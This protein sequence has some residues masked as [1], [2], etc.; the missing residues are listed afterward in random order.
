MMNRLISILLILVVA[1]SMATTAFAADTDDAQEAAAQVN[2]IETEEAEEI[3][4]ISSS[5]LF[6]DGGMGHVSSTSFE[7]KA[8]RG[9]GSIE[10]TVLKALEN[11]SSPIDVSEYKVSKAQ[12]SDLYFRLLDQ[13]PELF[14]VA[15]S[16]TYTFKADGTV[17]KVFP[18]FTMSI[19][20]IPQAKAVFNTGID[21]IM[22][23][24]DSSWNRTQTAAYLHDYV[25][26]HFAYDTR[27]NTGE[28]VN[29]DAYSMLTEGVGVCQAYTMLYSVLLRRAGIPVTTASSREMNH[30]WNL[31]QLENGNWYHVDTTW[32]DPMPNDDG[33]IGHTYFLKSDSGFTSLLHRNWTADYTCTDTSMDKGFWVKSASAYTAAAGIEN[34]K[35][36]ASTLYGVTQNYDNTSTLYMWDHTGKVVELEKLTN[37]YHTSLD[38]Y[39][40]YLVYND[41]TN[42]YIRNLCGST[43]EAVY[44]IPAAN[45][46]N[47][48]R[49]FVLR[50]AELTVRYYDAATRTVAS[51]TV[52][53]PQVAPIDLSTGQNT[54]ESIFTDV[55]V[56]DDCYEAVMWAVEN[57]ITSGTSAT[58]FSPEKITTRGQIV[59]F[60]WRAAGC[61]DKGVAGTFTD[62]K[63]GSY[64]EKAIAWAVAEGITNGTTATT[65][66]PNNTCSKA[67]C[68]TFLWRF[69]GQ[70]GS[71][72]TVSFTDVKAGAWYYNAVQWAV[73]NNIASGETATTF[74]PSTG[75]TRANFVTYLYRYMAN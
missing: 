12:F 19:D 11:C 7:G 38:S 44:S 50:G 20:Q 42:V 52:A 43:T 26:S 47:K 58:T 67:H 37:C 1:L 71:K 49:G 51:E 35:A 5:D 14:Y 27:V 55:S 15:G 48:V 2:V 69:A 25:V 6:R 39:N 59:T 10:N 32:D 64:C 46:S 4:T 66:S 34:G 24:V 3:E 22:A 75:L 72:G 29:H 40:G 62:V 45:K 36:F 33:T 23:S 30:M 18:A 65:F 28:A 16:I 73:T 9:A 68:L 8:V 54:A 21:A 17:S 57:G 61:P 31:V 74:A 41:N 63:A 60:L 56:N 70:P 53:M 13:N